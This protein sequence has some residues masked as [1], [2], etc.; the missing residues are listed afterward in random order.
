VCL[1]EGQVSSFKL[2]GLFRFVCL[3]PDSYVSF[4][5]L[6]VSFVDVYVSFVDLYVSFVVGLLLSQRRAGLFLQSPYIALPRAISKEIW[7]PSLVFCQCVCL[8]CQCVCLFC[9]CVCL[10]CR[11]CVCLRERQV[12]SFQT[13]VSAGLFLQNPYIAPPRA[14]SKETW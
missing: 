8:F 3:F 6:Y 10:F 9:Q 13:P 5:D 14:I 1:R 4:V 7:C 2:I 12:S 11:Q